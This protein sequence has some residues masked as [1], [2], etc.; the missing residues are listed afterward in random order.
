MVFVVLLPMVT[1][2]YIGLGL[3]NINANYYINEYGKEVI[4]PNHFIFL[5]TCIALLL[6]IIPILI[7]IRMEKREQTNA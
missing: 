5:G 6:A 4:A 7:F 3:S 2:P 1:G